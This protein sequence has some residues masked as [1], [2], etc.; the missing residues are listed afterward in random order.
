MKVRSYFIGSEKSDKQYLEYNYILPGKYHPSSFLNNL[1][2]P[3]AHQY[4]VYKLLIRQ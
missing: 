4:T 2:Y 3:V 1:D